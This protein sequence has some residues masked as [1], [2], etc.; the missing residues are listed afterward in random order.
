MSSRAFYFIRFSTISTLPVIIASQASP[1]CTHSVCFFRNIQMLVSPRVSRTKYLKRVF[2]SKG[3]VW[4]AQSRHAWV[5][6]N[7][8][9]SCRK[10]LQGG[11]S[12][13][14][15]CGSFAGHT[16]QEEVFMRLMVFAVQLEVREGEE[17]E[18]WE[19][20]KEG[21][22]FGRARK[23]ARKKKPLLLYEGHKGNSS[24]SDSA[25]EITTGIT[26]GKGYSLPHFFS[27]F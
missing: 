15:T 9:G 27:F 16:T 26:N 22:I 19:G 7:V 18:S 21:R 24:A 14:G 6:N 3:K 10:T 8:T 13:T 12:V 5:P 17:G 25:M 1:F 11:Q 4:N 23:K 20:P 2:P